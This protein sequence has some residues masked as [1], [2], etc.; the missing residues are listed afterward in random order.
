MALQQFLNFKWHG[1]PLCFFHCFCFTLLSLIGVAKG[2]CWC[3]CSHV[4]FLVL[5]LH[6]EQLPNW[7][8]REKISK[9]CCFVQGW[10]ITHF[11]SNPIHYFWYISNFYPECFKRQT[12]PYAIRK[13]I[14]RPV[15]MLKLARGETNK[16]ESPQEGLIPKTYSLL[17]LLVCLH[18][19]VLQVK[20]Q[21]LWGCP[22]TTYFLWPGV[23]GANSCC[24][25]CIST[26]LLCFMLYIWSI[27]LVFT[28][29][30]ELLAGL[31]EMAPGKAGL[32]GS[33]LLLNSN[34]NKMRIFTVLP[35]EIRSRSNKYSEGSCS[36][37][38]WDVEWNG[39]VLR[40]TFWKVSVNIPW[41][42]FRC[43]GLVSVFKKTG[44]LSRNF[45]VFPLIC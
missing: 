4:C 3:V 9:L 8:E 35:I 26:A 5:T 13:V 11:H 20:M 45:F 30:A 2:V 32:L 23:Q 18:F 44:A 17:P 43:L 36:Q 10:A 28:P 25:Y 12:L 21:G 33:T 37:I 42:A 6:P 31:C 24:Y 16:L 1:F 38:I 22:R 29:V 40:N 34:Q 19:N 14:Q 39:K 7:K 27:T 41:M 15:E